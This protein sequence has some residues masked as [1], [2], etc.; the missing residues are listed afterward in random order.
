MMLMAAVRRFQRPLLPHRVNQAA[1]LFFRRRQSY[2]FSN[3]ENASSSNHDSKSSHKHGGGPASYS[4]REPSSSSSTTTTTTIRD[5]VKV[6]SLGKGVVHVLLSR[7][8]KLNSLDIPMF[9]AIA[10]AAS[11]LRDDPALN[12]NLRAIVMSGEG[13]AFC[14]G[15]D[16]KGVALSGSSPSESTRRLLE[17]PSSYGGEGGLGNLAQDVCYLWRRV[18]S[19]SSSSPQFCFSYFSFG[20]IRLS[21]NVNN[22]DG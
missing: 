4:I 21:L 16:A 11:R 18:S 6:I 10:E 17:R 5:R 1:R 14:T 19:G 15:L 3:S 20:L 22:R 12:R 2:A 13:R 8:E 7:P 9:E